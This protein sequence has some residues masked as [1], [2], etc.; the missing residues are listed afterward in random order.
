MSSGGQSVLTYLH[1]EHA[2]CWSDAFW[3]FPTGHWELSQCLTAGPF[4]HRAAVVWLETQCFPHLTLPVLPVPQAPGRLSGHSSSR[5]CLE[6]CD[7]PTSWPQRHHGH[8]HYYAFSNSRVPYGNV[9][10]ELLIF[11]DEQQVVTSD[12][13]HCRKQKL[14]WGASGCDTQALCYL[15]T[16]FV[17]NHHELPWLSS[18]KKTTVS[19]CCSNSGKWS[20][21]SMQKLIHHSS[22]KRHWGRG[23]CPLY[24]TSAPC[25]DKAEF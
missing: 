25:S 19:V 22:I 13:G 1:S 9:R 12:N 2:Q 7:V 8:R 20:T 24:I 21:Q 17:G 11:W 23:Q 5:S 16:A 18:L 10:K 14:G 15:S 6:L 3:H 4:T